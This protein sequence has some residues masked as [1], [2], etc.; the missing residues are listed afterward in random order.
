MNF[1]YIH[2]FVKIGIKGHPQRH[3]EQIAE[4]DSLRSTISKKAKS[5]GAAHRKPHVPEL[6]TGTFHD[7]PLSSQLQY[8]VSRFALAHFSSHYTPTTVYRLSKL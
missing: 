2:L 7:D 5:Y 1:F 8:H 4:F 3:E 6:G